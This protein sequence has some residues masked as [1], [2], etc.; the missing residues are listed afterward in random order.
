MALEGDD[1]E[2]EVV[3]GLRSETPITSLKR[4]RPSYVR[5]QNSLLREYEEVRK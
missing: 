4:A 2:E 3:A 5:L 1:E